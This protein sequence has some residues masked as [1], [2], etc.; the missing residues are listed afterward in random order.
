MYSSVVYASSFETV[1][2]LCQTGLLSRCGHGIVTFRRFVEAESMLA[3]PS[4]SILLLT[5]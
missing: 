1:G 5:S 2:D 3:V 4:T